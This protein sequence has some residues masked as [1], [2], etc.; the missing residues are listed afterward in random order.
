[1]KRTHF[2]SIDQYIKVYPPKVQAR[3][4]KLRATI[5]KAAPTTT[6]AI[7]YDMPTFKLNGNLVHFAAYAKHIGFYPN[8][9]AIRAF[10]KDVF[11]F[12]WS[13]GAVQFSH[14][15]P[16]PLELVTKMVKFRVKENLTREKSR[17]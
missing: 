16:L 6:E 5:H 11:K 2:K 13:K 15:L 7:S 14:E 3:M 12:K 1:M 8:P 10:K 9:S 4:R 17:Y